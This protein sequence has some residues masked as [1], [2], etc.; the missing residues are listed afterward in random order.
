LW[1]GKSASQD[2]VLE[3]E[4]FELRL[5]ALVVDIAVPSLPN[6]LFRDNTHD[7]LLL[8]HAIV[9]VSCSNGTVKLLKLPLDPPSHEDLPNAAAV[10][11]EST[12]AEVQTSVSIR[13][14][15]QYLASHADFTSQ[16]LDDRYE[17]HL[18]VASCAKDG[19]PSLHV[20]FFTIK[21]SGKRGL[22]ASPSSNMQNVPLPRQPLKV[23]Y[24]PGQ[25][26]PAVLVV[27]GAG[28]LYIYQPYTVRSY[29]IAGGIEKRTLSDGLPPCG[30]F[31][32]SFSTPFTKQ[33]P[34]SQSR[35]ARK[36]ILDAGWVMQGD[37][38][39]VLLADRTWGIWKMSASGLSDPEFDLAF[40]IPLD[41]YQP[42]K[43]PAIV[44]AGGI[45]ILGVVPANLSSADDSLII[46]FDGTIKIVK[47][48]QSL[49]KSSGGGNSCEKNT[50]LRTT[51]LSH[52]R[53]DFFSL[54]GF[55][56]KK[57]N[58]VSVDIIDEDEHSTTVKR[59]PVL[60]TEHSLIFS[61]PFGLNA[62]H[63][64]V[65]AMRSIASASVASPDS[66]AAKRWKGMNIQT[67]VKRFRKPIEAL[68]P[69]TPALYS[70]VHPTRKKC[71]LT[72]SEI[73]AA[74]SAIEQRN[75]RNL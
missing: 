19:P 54:E 24:Q 65:L 46:W 34:E 4:S 31:A 13:W 45:S 18:L 42:P 48:L 57:H 64:L 63:C 71:P 40:K 2:N 28:H 37:G 22:A 23:A 39:V 44:S 70:R 61:A 26:D 6:L 47:S 17:A 36:R 55:Q 9:A 43:V 21:D 5:N 1:S 16:K 50:P 75:K 3:F 49:L 35:L 73:G 8:R 60:I 51:N 32:A 7:F 74:L 62:S 30:S 68:P 66:S 25:Q 11:F 15:V 14:D 58:I 69:N 67:T 27:C 52:E 33:K 20:S 41:P 56:L 10:L 59:R 38:I 12:Y 72:V 53:D 29:T